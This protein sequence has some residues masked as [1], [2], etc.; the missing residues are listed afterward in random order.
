M[1]RSDA[2]ARR[3]F[4]RAVESIKPKPDGSVPPDANGRPNT[5]A[6]AY[7]GLGEKAKALEQAQRSV[8]DYDTDAVNKPSAQTALAQ[9]QARIGDFDSAIAALPHLLEVPAGIAPAD[10]RFNPFW[11]RCA[12]PRSPGS[13]SLCP[14]A[15][16]SKLRSS[17]G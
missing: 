3:S 17:Y 10:L 16:K 7:A 8:K 13:A 2:D 15:P 14:K 9:I 11:I 6:L 4:S 5:L 1:D 12:D